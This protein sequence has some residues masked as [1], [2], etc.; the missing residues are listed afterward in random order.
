MIPPDSGGFSAAVWLTPLRIVAKNRAAWF[1]WTRQLSPSKFQLQ[2][3]N[4]PLNNYEDG[5]LKL[6]IDYISIA[7]ILILVNPIYQYIFR[8]LC[9][10]CCDAALHR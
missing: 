7:H 8:T 1:P 5:T 9:V 3:F 10:S 6:H 2:F 4:F